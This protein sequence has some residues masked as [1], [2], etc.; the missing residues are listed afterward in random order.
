MA[1]YSQGER[2]S[3]HVWITILVSLVKSRTLVYAFAITALGTFL[4]STEGRFTD[5]TIPVRLII[6]TYVLALATYLYND[7]TDNQTDSIN[8][9]R[10]E[11]RLN[12]K[13]KITVWYTTSFFIVG[14]LLA[15]SINIGTGVA[16]VAFMVLAIA[17]SHRS[18]QLKNRFVIKTVVTGAGS[19]IASLMGCL[20]SGALSELG[21]IAS[22]IPFLFYF[23]LGPMGDIGDLKGD[24][25]SGR[26][27]IPI[28]I[29]IKKS[30]IIM[31]LISGTIAIIFLL[32]G[33]FLGLNPAGVV[34]GFLVVSYM[35]WNINKASKHHI[36]KLQLNSCRRSI[37]FCI[38]ASQISL[39]I[40][41][42]LV[43]AV[44]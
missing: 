11:L 24:K 38:F 10:T 15:F 5:I 6:S 18:I 41:S 13:R 33:I 2:N 16:S 29:G 37:R 7:L 39:L 4:I 19:F 43:N 30:F 23:I 14:I 27:T 22:L 17:Y 9:R 35:M 1:V 34:L 42:L 36:D 44:F 25:E 28:V 32:S 12:F 26:R 31:G 20:S 8:N 40:G 3:S 21:V